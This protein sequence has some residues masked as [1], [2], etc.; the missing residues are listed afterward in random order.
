MQVSG[1]TPGGSGNAHG[2]APAIPVQN[3]NFGLRRSQYS[4]LVCFY[5]N[6]HSIHPMDFRCLD[7]RLLT[8]V[9]AKLIAGIHPMAVVIVGGLVTSTLLNLFVMPTLSLRYARPERVRNPAILSA[10]KAS[11]LI[12]CG[13]PGS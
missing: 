9:L 12:G 6:E 2:T 10:K 8:V 1:E 13:L 11:P 3:L 7:S 4:T 5:F